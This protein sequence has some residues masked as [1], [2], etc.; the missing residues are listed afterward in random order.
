M[1]QRPQKCPTPFPALLKDHHYCFII[2]LP[3]LSPC[4]PKCTHHNTQA[5]NVQ[6]MGIWLCVC[7]KHM[8]IL[9]SLGSN[10][11]QSPSH[12]TLW[13]SN[14]NTLSSTSFPTAIPL[15]PSICSALAQRL[16]F[17]IEPYNKL[18]TSTCCPSF[19][20]KLR[21]GGKEGSRREGSHLC[22]GAIGSMFKGNRDTIFQMQNQ[23]S[24]GEEV[25]AMS[26]FH[27]AN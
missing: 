16:C 21:F 25:A 22:N 24:Q 20:E 1:K 4:H 14:N 7:V 5:R 8:I 26:K 9:T 18:E 27:G 2:I 19:L 13:S 6:G 12:T 17:C 10:I 15:V 3:N 11:T 23:C